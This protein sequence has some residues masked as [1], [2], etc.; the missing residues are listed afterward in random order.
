MFCFRTKRR[1]YDLVEGNLTPDQ[2]KS[3]KAH[4]I[5]CPGCGRQYRQMS[6]VINLASKQAVPQPSGQFWTNFDR[7]LE[8]K[9]TGEKI[10][11]LDVKLR[12][13]RLPRLN[14]KPA[15]ALASVF[16]LIL[17]FSFYLFGGLPTKTRIVALADEQLINDIELIEEISDEFIVVEDPAALRQELSLLEDL[18]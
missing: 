16:A 2:A 5:K 12:P 15:F 7:E 18:S 17:A 1:L 9:L 6:Q 11:P 13:D 10:K 8:E 14:L 3:L 4:L